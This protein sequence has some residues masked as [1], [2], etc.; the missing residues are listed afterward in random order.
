M[1]AADRT[2]STA[3]PTPRNDVYSIGLTANALWNVLSIWE[4][5][6]PN[7]AKHTARLLLRHAA[8]TANQVRMTGGLIASQPLATSCGSLKVRPDGLFAQNV[9]PLSS[10]LAVGRESPRHDAGAKRHDR[11]LHFRRGRF[12][13]QAKRTEIAEPITDEAPIAWEMFE[14]TT[15]RRMVEIMSVPFA[16]EDQET[17]QRSH[18]RRPVSGA[19]VAAG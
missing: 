8:C 18:A 11:R 10:R 6:D 2:N 5:L 1:T 7:R 13:R 12:R 17:S 16:V 3:S 14:A 19:G 9:G 15:Q 4:P